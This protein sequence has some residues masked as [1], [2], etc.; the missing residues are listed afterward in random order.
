MIDEKILRGEGLVKG[1]WD[2][3]KILGNGDFSK[4]LS[5]KVHA[6]SA[7]AREKIEKAGGSI[8][9]VAGRTFPERNSAKKAFAEKV[10]NK[11]KPKAK[12]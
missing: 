11:P 12:A 8:E 1:T 10:K 5:L 2:G 3:V 4:K 7:S 9:L 6:I